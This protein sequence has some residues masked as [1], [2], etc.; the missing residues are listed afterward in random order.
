MC[1][2]RALTEGKPS[3]WQPTEAGD[4]VSGVILR[5]DRTP[6]PFSPTGDGVL[7]VDLWLGGRE[8]IRITAYGAFLRAAIDQTEPQVG[9]T[10]G[11]TFEGE[12]FI[13]QG[14]HAGR[15]YKAYSAMIQ[16]G[17]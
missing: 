11:V 17:H 7:F 8:R 3:M 14:K 2:V 15:P 13:D 10:L 9:D 6:N 12:R 4:S 1:A 16:R 5:M